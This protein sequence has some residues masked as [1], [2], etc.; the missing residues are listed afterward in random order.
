LTKSTCA[1]NNL[2]QMFYVVSD[3]P[4]A[5]L[6]P[7]YDA[8]WQPTLLPYGGLKRHSLLGDLLSIPTV[9][10]ASTSS[11]PLMGGSATMTV[12]WD[13]KDNAY[14][15]EACTPGVK[16]DELKLEIVGRRKLE[17]AIEQ[18]VKPE[19]QP[20]SQ[21]GGEGM[22]NKDEK[23]AEE[24]EPK[25]IRRMFTSVLLPEDADTSSAHVEYVD[26]VL[27]VRFAKLEGDKKVAIDLDAEHAGLVQEV[28]SRLDKVKELRAKLEAEVA[29][30]AKAE[31]SLRRA[32]VEARRKVESERAPLKLQ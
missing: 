2:N 5:T 29:E 27:R 26:G 31:E 20:S 21:E 19:Q 4:A 17:L 18:G 12:R 16:R 13:K 22:N 11:L 3:R 15:V 28:S 24:G 8:V 9:L 1:N 7:L 23:G 6:D 25:F 32:R 30:A 10:D 14:V